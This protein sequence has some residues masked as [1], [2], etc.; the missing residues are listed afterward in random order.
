VIIINPGSG[1]VPDATEE[2]AAAAMAVFCDDLR[3]QGKAVAGFDRTAGDDEGRFA[4]DV[5]LADGEKH[6]IEMPGL[7]VDQVRYLGEPQN[8]W[9]FPRLYVDGSSWVWCFALNACQ[10]EDEEG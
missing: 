7:P 4:F 10:R 9:D 1:P 2:N 3:A 8:I 6:Q 5:I